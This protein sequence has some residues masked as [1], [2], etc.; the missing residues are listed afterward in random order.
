MKRL[1]HNNIAE[2]SK[3]YSAIQEGTTFYHVT[4]DDAINYLSTKETNLILSYMISTYGWDSLD[5]SKGL[6]GSGLVNNDLY[7]CQT[8]GYDIDVNGESVDPES[9]FDEYGPENLE[10]YIEEATPQ[11]IKRM[12][13]P[14]ELIEDIDMNEV[15]VGIISSGHDFSELLK[16][17]EDIDRL[18]DY[19]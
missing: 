7:I 15:A 6:F 2:K 10:S 12:I 16:S 11:I 4:L 13:T 17:L 19:M 3:I 9:A 5:F 8:D 14:Y 18:K 1:K